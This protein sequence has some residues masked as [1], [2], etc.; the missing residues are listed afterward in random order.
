MGS[1]LIYTIKVL[2]KLLTNLK[3][4][5]ICYKLTILTFYL[6]TFALA[7]VSKLLYYF[8]RLCLVSN[9]LLF[10]HMIV[11]CSKCDEEGKGFSQNMVKGL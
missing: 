8:L 11:C 6:N 1:D 7:I 10:A 2:T 4:L 3:G 9:G 5:A